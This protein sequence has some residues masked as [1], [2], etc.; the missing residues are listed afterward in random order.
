MYNIQCTW[1]LDSITGI[2]FKI[3]ILYLESRFCNW[4]PLFK[5]QILAH[6]MLIMRTAV[7]TVLVMRTATHKM[8]IMSTVA[9]T[10]GLC[11]LLCIQCWLCTLLCMQ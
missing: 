9:R 5:I 11:T 10:V 8:S 3:Q 7:H 1:N 4:N 6:T 2:F